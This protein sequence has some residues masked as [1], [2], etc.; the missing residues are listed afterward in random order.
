DAVGPFV[1]DGQQVFAHIVA[2]HADTAGQV[3]DE[4]LAAAIRGIDEF[5]V[6]G[7]VLFGFLVPPDFPA[8]VPINPEHAAAARRSN[9]D[10]LIDDGGLAQNG[11]AAEEAPHQPAVDHIERV[12]GGILGADVGNF[13]V[14]AHGGGYVAVKLVV[15]ADSGFPGRILE[16]VDGQE[17]AV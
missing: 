11:G 7:E 17:G 4:Q 3:H 13:A 15:K 5:L 16:L 8:G 10:I 12:Q 6:G 14:L 2:S 9:E 1:A